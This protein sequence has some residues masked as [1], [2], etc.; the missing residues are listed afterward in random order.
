MKVAYVYKN[1]I[2]RSYL[3]L[4]KLSEKLSVNLINMPFCRAWKAASTY[5][6]SFQIRFRKEKMMSTIV[7]IS[8]TQKGYI[9]KHYLGSGI[10]FL[11]SIK[12]K[13]NAQK[14]AEF[15]ALSF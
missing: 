3:T 5:T 1:I 11:Y 15:L 14:C 4:R 12:N 8:S 6:I 7:I 10:F 9:S 2:Y 13:T